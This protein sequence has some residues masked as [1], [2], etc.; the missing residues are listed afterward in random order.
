VISGQ[1][2]YV[3]LNALRGWNTG[4]SYTLTLTYAP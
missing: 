1:D 4:E 3:Y 2:Y